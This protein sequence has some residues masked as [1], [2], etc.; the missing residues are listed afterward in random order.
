M[1]TFGKRW[2]LSTSVNHPYHALLNQFVGLMELWW[3]HNSSSFIFIQLVPTKQSD[4]FRMC[5]NQ[6]GSTPYS[7]LKIW[8]QSSAD[9]C[10][11]S[12]EQPAAGWPGKHETFGGQPLGQPL[13]QLYSLTCW[14]AEVPHGLCGQSPN[15]RTTARTHLAAGPSTV[16]VLYFKVACD[17]DNNPIRWLAKARHLKSDGQNILEEI[18]MKTYTRRDLWKE[19]SEQGIYLFIFFSETFFI[20]LE[21]NHKPHRPPAGCSCQL[22]KPHL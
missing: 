11:V 19:K 15:T 6:H 9:V 3:P 17:S 4:W 21:K 16:F 18:I 10:T 22:S 1:L 5:S 7:S 2:E 14:M 13:G 12:M 20:T 8:L